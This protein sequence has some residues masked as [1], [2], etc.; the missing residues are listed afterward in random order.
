MKNYLLFLS[1]LLIAIATFF[2]CQKEK[3]EAELIP[4]TAIAFE[5]TYSC[6]GCDDCCCIIMST[7]LFTHNAE[8]CFQARMEWW[9]GWDG[10]KD[11]STTFGCLIQPNQCDTSYQ[12][13]QIQYDI[14]FE[15]D[16]TD[17]NYGAYGA[18]CVESSF[19]QVCN[20]HSF[21]ITMHLMCNPDA[22]GH[23]MQTFSLQPFECKVFYYDNDCDVV[24]CQ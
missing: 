16:S 4:N 6:E 13:G 15:N 17:A 3:E 11:V 22:H 19:V 20:P 10:A 23:Q 5:R 21:S 1:L 2:A 24:A 7:E 18:F 9:L 8:V 14:E 12:F